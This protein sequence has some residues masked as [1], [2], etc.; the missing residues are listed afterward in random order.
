MVLFY[1]VTLIFSHKLDI[2]FENSIGNTHITCKNIMIKLLEGLHVPICTTSVSYINSKTQTL[3]CL[4]CRN[5]WYVY[6]LQKIQIL[7]PYHI[8]KTGSD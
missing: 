6:H 5:K 1:A 8:A 2:G 3:P 4:K 7:W